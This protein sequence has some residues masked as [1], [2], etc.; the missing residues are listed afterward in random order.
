MKFLLLFFLFACSIG[1]FFIGSLDTY[2]TSKTADRL[3]LYTKQETALGLDIEK[4]FN[5]VKPQIKIIEQNL[6]TLRAKSSLQLEKELV[7]SSISE[8]VIAYNLGVELVNKYNQQMTEKQYGLFMKDYK[9]KLEKKQKKHNLKR[10]KK[11]VP[12][13]FEDIFGE[14]RK[15]QTELLKNNAQVFLNWS[16]RRFLQEDVHY[17]SLVVAQSKADLKERNELVDKAY[18]TLQNSVD[19]DFK[20]HLNA[21]IKVI[22]QFLQTLNDSQRSELN[23]KVDLALG[24]MEAF[25]NHRY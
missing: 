5:Q 21:V 10:Y 7:D 18:K 9:K 8:F 22:N 4:L 19:E 23:E 17:K 24:I 11:I 14:L 2:V 16:K 25:I 6:K 3:Q 1:R 13:K 15:D 20:N 12:K